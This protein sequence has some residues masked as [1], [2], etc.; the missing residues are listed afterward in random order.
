MNL[1]KVQKK[2]RMRIEHFLFYDYTGIEHHLETMAQRGWLLK[3]CG[4]FFW[5]YEAIPPQQ[6]HFCVTYVPSL[7]DYDPL[8][9]EKQELYCQLCESAGWTLA[10]GYK[11]MLIFCSKD[12][13]PLPLETDPVTK[14]DTISQTMRKTMIPS[15]FL[16]LFLCCFQLFQ[17]PVRIH[18]DPTYFFSSPLYTML[19]LLYLF[20]FVGT[21]AEMIPYFRWK[22][23]S[24]IALEAGAAL[25]PD[26]GTDTGRILSFCFIQL[27]VL[28]LIPVFLFQ[29][30]LSFFRLILVLAAIVLGIFYAG[31][32]QE[33]LR[34]KGASRRKNQV[35]TGVSSVVIQILVL[36]LIT[37]CILG[38][39]IFGDPL[40]TENSESYYVP[41]SEDSLRFYVEMRHDILPLTAEDLTD[42]KDFPYYSYENSSQSTPFVSYSEMNQMAL[43][44]LEDDPPELYYEIT[45]I[46]WPALYEMCLDQF[47]KDE[48]MS[49]MQQTWQPVSAGDWSCSDAW[50]R[51]SGAEPDNT[52]LLAGKD[53]EDGY[54][55]I[56]KITFYWTPTAEQ[57][58]TAGEKLFL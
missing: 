15:W 51:Y 2:E 28:C 36:G 29:P 33:H 14:L 13:D 20:L 4:S 48:H 17:V 30:D 11:K 45:D 53:P 19:P 23:K 54:R 5:H 58:E 8:P 50:R 40:G 31:Q 55:R 24:I 26:P 3:K 44:H 35:I 37:F 57:I 9:N 10:T 42:T 49:D 39:A 12:D 52:W 34:E 18:Q 22:K 41:D 25:L 6:V 47:L 43:G 27:S 21:I 56:V 46:K 16:L 38:F 32:V 7:S 1:P